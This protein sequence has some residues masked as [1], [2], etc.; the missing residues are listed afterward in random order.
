MKNQKIIFKL[1]VS[2]AIVT[3]LLS[4]LIISCFLKPINVSNTFTVYSDDDYYSETTYFKDEDEF[5]K[6]TSANNQKNSV[7]ALNQTS[8]KKFVAG[9]E[10]KVWVG[11]TYGNNGQTINSRLLKKSEVESL[12]CLEEQENLNSSMVQSSATHS[13]GGDKESYYALSIK[14]L[15]FLPGI[16]NILQKILNKCLK[17]IMKI[18]PVL[19][20][21]EKELYRAVAIKCRVNM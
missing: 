4:L 1:I 5:Y 7:K 9:I 19:L 11:E 10:K 6:R 20:G 15:H 14:F 8:D 18:M 21:A 17:W 16:A 3:A 2:C 13:L 12:S